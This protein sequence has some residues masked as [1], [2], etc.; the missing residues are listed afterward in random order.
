MEACDKS[1]EKMVNLELHVFCAERRLTLELLGFERLPGGWF[2]LAM[3]KIDIVKSW[4]NGSF[5]E[6]NTWKKDIRKLVEDFHRK[7]LVHGDLLLANFIFTKD[8]PCRMLLVDF[9]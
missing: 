7:G 5:S 4:E 3:K 8:S 2:A 1:L 9:D 6:L